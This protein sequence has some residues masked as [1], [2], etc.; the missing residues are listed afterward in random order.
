MMFYVL[1][2]IFYTIW[3]SQPMTQI[4]SLNMHSASSVLWTLYSGPQTFW[5]QGQF[6]WKK[7][8]PLTEGKGVV[9]GWFK[10]ITFIV[11]F[12]SIIITQIYPRSSDISTQRLGTT[13]LIS[14]EVMT[15]N[16]VDVASD[17]EQELGKVNVSQSEILEIIYI[18]EDLSP[19]TFI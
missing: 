2:Q 14:E 9:S 8:I 11:Y 1:F 16:P 5:H 17:K 13:A 15:M 10:C 4:Q 3:S 7:I 19:M 12:I 18:V 6:T